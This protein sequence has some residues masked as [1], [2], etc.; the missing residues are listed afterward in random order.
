MRRSSSFLQPYPRRLGRRRCLP[1]RTP[2]ISESS[3]QVKAANLLL[4]FAAFFLLAFTWSP[5]NDRVSRQAATLSV[6]DQYPSIQAAIDAANPGDVVSVKSGTYQ[7]NVTVNKAITLT[8][9]TFDEADPTQNATI[10]DGGGGSEDITILVPPDISPMPTVR[11]FVI[12]NA[13]SGIQLWS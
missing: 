6:P 5:S 4:V 1:V 8:A 7:E 9:E 12:V 13:E 11:G 10:I 3:F 2:G